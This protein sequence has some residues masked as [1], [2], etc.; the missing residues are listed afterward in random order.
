ME[1]I[2]LIGSVITSVTIIFS[3]VITLY[4]VVRKIDKK[5]EN[6]EENLK[7]NQLSILRLI[8]INENMPLDERVSAGEKYVEMGGNGGVH[9]LYEV[10]KEKYKEHL[11]G[12]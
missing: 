6:Y 10:I 4:K 9:A 12:K 11:K 8:I 7:D 2:I 5:I 1:K 3:T